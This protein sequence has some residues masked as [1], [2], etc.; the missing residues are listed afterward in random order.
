MNG[1]S[2]VKSAKKAYEL[3]KDKIICM[4]YTYALVNDKNIKEAKKVL[5]KVG[6]D[7]LK[8]KQFYYENIKNDTKTLIEMQHCD[9]RNCKL[10]LDLMNYYLKNNQIMEA[11][12]IGQRHEEYRG[13]STEVREILSK[14][15]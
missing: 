4:I 10:T 11:I 14:L 12:K 8:L 15:I 13:Q 1:K 3:S 7:S 2:G 5:L 6:A 9:P